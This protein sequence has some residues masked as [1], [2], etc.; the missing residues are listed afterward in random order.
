MFD[1]F[2]QKLT[3][4][5]LDLSDISLKVA[6]LKSDGRGLALANYGRQEIPR[7]VIEGGAI[8]KVDE[9]V[10]VIKKG[11]LSVN[12]L[13]INTKYCVVSLPETESFI[14][15]A[16]LPKMKLDELSKAVRWEVESQ[17][18]LPIDQVYFDWQIVEPVRASPDHYDIVI[19]ALSRSLVDPYLEVLKEAG[20]KPL[21]FE[22]E[23]VATSRAL[24]ENEFISSPVMII[25]IGARRTSFIIFAGRTIHFTASLSISNEYLVKEIARQLDVSLERAKEL[26]FEVGLD[27]EREKGRVFKS[28]LPSMN[29]IVGQIGNYIDFYQTHG[30]GGHFETKNVSKIFLCGGGANLNGL[31]SFLSDAL[32]LSVEVGNPW[33]N[34]LKASPESIPEL[35]YDQSISYTTVLG[36]ALRGAR[37]SENEPC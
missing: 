13:P 2:E 20:L 32:N 4:F 5:G 1:F 18:P 17:I 14:R 29:E 19:G 6:Q 21:V 8:K 25:D 30:L 24:I 23:S 7:G 35:P 37:M 26:K 31:P 27:K 22:I 11:V 34:I 28:L 33:V 9:L 12:G 15:V 16:Q 10:N 3:A 36:L